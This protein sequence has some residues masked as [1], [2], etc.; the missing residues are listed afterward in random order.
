[1]E[2]HFHDFGTSSI[3]EKIRVI[4]KGGGV[5]SVSE[6]HKLATNDHLIIICFGEDDFH[7]SLHQIYQTLHFKVSY[8]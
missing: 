1:M 7:G 4:F 2:K 8:S 6:I 5:G 3:F